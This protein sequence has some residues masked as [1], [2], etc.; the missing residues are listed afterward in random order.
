MSALVGRAAT[1]AL[2]TADEAGYGVGAR[3]RGRGNV[4]RR[5]SDGSMAAKA[6]VKNS[7]LV[8]CVTGGMGAVIGLYGGLIRGTRPAFSSAAMGVNSGA[9]F[10]SVYML[11]ELFSVSRAKLLKLEPAPDGADGFMAGIAAGGILSWMQGRRGMPALGGV[12]W[13]GMIVG[14]VDRSL[15]RGLSD[16]PQ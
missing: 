3:G 2:E 13:A 15:S 10:A 9:F 1:D 6:I 16:R 12:L 11:R 8:G 4:A 7:L 5:V 14:M